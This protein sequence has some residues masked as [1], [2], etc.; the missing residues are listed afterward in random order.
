MRRHIAKVLPFVMAVLIASSCHKEDDNEVN[1]PPTPVV[2]ENA[3]VQDNN[4]AKEVPFSVTVATGK[5]LSKI[6][7]EDQNGTVM[8][9][10]EE[11]EE[12]KLEMEIFNGT[13]KIGTLKLIDWK[14]G[15]FSGPIAPDGLEQ[16]SPLTGKITV[17][18]SGEHPEWS[19]LSI[20]ALMQTCGHV[21]E[22][23]GL[24]YGTT[25]VVDLIDD[26]AYLEILSNKTDYDISVNG[27]TATTHSNNTWI[28]VAGVSTISSTALSLTNRT[29]EPN[30]IYTIR[31][32]N[33]S[34]ITID[35]SATVAVGKS[36]QLT[37]TADPVEAPVKKWTSTDPTIARVDESGVV[38]AFKVGTTTIKATAGSTESN[39]CIVTVTA[40]E[41]TI[42]W[43]QDFINNIDGYVS[44]GNGYTTN[45]TNS[46][47]SVTAQGTGETMLNFS[48]GMINCMEGSGSIT[49]TSS[50]GKIKKIEISAMMIEN[51][52]G[53]GWSIDYEYGA[54]WEGT[55][56][57]SVS[58]NVGQVLGI[59]QI[60]FTVELNEIVPVSAIT[61]NESNATIVVGNTEQLSVSSIAPDN[62]TDKT[63]TWS[64]SDESIATVDQT[65]KVTA[66][67]AGKATVY[68]TA[69]D[70]SGVKGG[71]E[72]TVKEFEIPS[73][74]RI[75]KYGANQ[76]V[77]FNPGKEVDWASLDPGI[78][79]VD[80]NG[81]VTYVSA[82][83]AKITATANGATETCEV[84]AVFGI[85]TPDRDASIEEVFSEPVYCT[86]LITINGSKIKFEHTIGGSYDVLKLD[87]QQIY[88][89]DWNVPYII[90]VSGTG[91]S[92][93][94][95]VL[96]KSW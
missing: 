21:Y 13:N 19:A 87:G 72:I 78:A 38:T 33:V 48:G 44:D 31:R 81:V 96:E 35:N 39:E 83:T 58:M 37:A 30:H 65:G 79:Q 56:A 53:D 36:T 18:A 26:K 51:C 25:G 94:P 20:T 45:N 91:T 32:Y 59:S 12:N 88:L 16:S 61:L 66:I 82:G 67:A 2:E 75:F 47:I 22:T 42:I 54:T 77:T 40:G 41:N 69:K 76:S 68:A 11:S 57:N 84:E 5:R 95:Y 29:T 24:T 70:G 46:G 28:A 63:Y 8:P 92:S 10:F 9:S 71:C 60:V 86:G 1:N 34:S 49:F 73:S 85:G 7:Y 52:S 23:K 62:A 27:G 43:T 6:T 14:L 55:A 89:G 15:T 74:A 17:A 80:E 90:I 3:G 4:N 93:D 50:V 64:S